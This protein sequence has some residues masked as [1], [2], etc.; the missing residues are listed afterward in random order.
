MSV[1]MVY[2][3]H[4]HGE[5]AQHS[6]HVRRQT[7]DVTK[8]QARQSPVLSCVSVPACACVYVDVRVC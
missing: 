7:S 2:T 3:A 4:S 5:G 8:S 1:K 6:K